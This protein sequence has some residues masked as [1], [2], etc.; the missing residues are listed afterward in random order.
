MVIKDYDLNIKMNVKK[1]QIKLVQQNE[2]KSM[3]WECL[4]YEKLKCTR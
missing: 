4:Y 3:F 2:E 1:T